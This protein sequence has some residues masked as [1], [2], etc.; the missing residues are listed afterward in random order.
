M[1]K[2]NTNNQKTTLQKVDALAR[3][4]ETLPAYR[5]PYTTDARDSIKLT[6]VTGR[7]E[8]RFLPSGAVEVA[9]DLDGTEYGV[10]ATRTFSTMQFA[11]FTKVDI[12][13]VQL[14]GETVAYIQ[15]WGADALH[16][17]VR[18]W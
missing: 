18:T 2:N 13:H 1:R 3:L 16:F 6:D 7:L 11:N 15:C 9:V 12:S 4:R 14:K 5:V 17:M 10:G 8:V